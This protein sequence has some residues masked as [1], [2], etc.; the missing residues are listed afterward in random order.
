[1]FDVMVRL[2]VICLVL[3]PP[4]SVTVTSAVFSSKLNI[5]KLSALE[6]KTSSTERKE[7]AQHLATLMGFVVQRKHAV[8]HRRKHA[9]D[10]KHFPAQRS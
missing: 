1:M 9:I 4:L 7:D 8:Y 6:K 3:S 10:V 5:F 2:C